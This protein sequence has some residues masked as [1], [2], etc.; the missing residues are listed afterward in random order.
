MINTKNGHKISN[1]VIDT[2]FGIAGNGIFP[3]KLLPKNQK[4]LEMAQKT[5]TTILGKSFTFL[6]RIGNLVT[7]LPWTWKYIQLLGNDGMLNACGIANKGAKKEA[8][9][10][11]KSVKKYKN[12]IPNFF[13][14]FTKGDDDVWEQTNKTIKALIFRLG[15]LFHALVLNFSCPNT[16][17]D[18]TRIIKSASLLV[19]KINQKYPWL[20]IIAKISYVQ[21]LE[22]A[23]EL[24][25]AGA[26]IIQAINTI[27]YSLVFPKSKSPLAKVGGGG[28]SGGPIKEISL[29]YNNVLRKR[30]RIPIAM[31]GGI[32]SLEDCARFE[33]IGANSLTICT[34]ARR[35]PE[36]AMDIIFAK[37]FA[38]D[39]IFTKN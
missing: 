21:P 17:E 3:L 18:I 35:D 32:M 20:T 13:P 24:E 10:I 26:E 4:L 29:R 19:R 6:K 36:T 8:K 15:E 39:L 12:F 22:F 23:E 27:P 11:G 2:I 9:K 25:I 31:G 1:V 30:V 38:M 16:E 37:N 28:V 34:V 14:D 7:Y 5:N 33:G